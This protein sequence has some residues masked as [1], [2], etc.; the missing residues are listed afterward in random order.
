MMCLLYMYKYTPLRPI[1]SPIGPRFDF[2][3]FFFLFSSSLH[4]ARE[5]VPLLVLPQAT[6]AGDGQA[7]LSELLGD[8]LPA[9]DGHLLVDGADLFAVHRDVGQARQV[10]LRGEQLGQ[11]LAAALGRVDRQ[12]QQVLGGARSAELRVRDQAARELVDALAD[13]YVVPS[14]VFVEVRF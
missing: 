14:L 13:L 3:L 5:P 11:L 2:F 4:L 10:T 12:R 9:A 8:D 7:A 6:S 1:P